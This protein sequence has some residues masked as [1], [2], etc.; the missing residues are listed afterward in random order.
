MSL[1]NGLKLLLISAAAFAVAFGLRRAFFWDVMPVSW[2]QEP[3][4]LW[5][6]GAAFMLRSIE[7]LAMV[8]AAIVVAFIVA[9]LV[10]NRFTSA[11][12]GAG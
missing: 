9:V 12:P 11:P 4:S 10:R 5:A 6:L 3:Q 2:D 8:V 7:N 1:Q